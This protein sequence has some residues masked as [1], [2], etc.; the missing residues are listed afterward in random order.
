V[1]AARACAFAGAGTPRKES[2]KLIVDVHTHIGELE[3]YGELFREGEERGAT[4]ARSTGLA[5]TLAAHWEAMRDI[6]RAIVVGFKTRLLGC[7]VPNDYVAAYVNQHPEKL[8]GFMSVDPTQAGAV[9]EFERCH[10]DLGLRGIKMSPI[11]QGFHP[12]AAEVLPLYE[13]AQRHGLP[14]L[15]HQAACYNRVAPL[16]Y[17]HPLLFDEIAI[18]FPELTLVFAHL[19]Y[20]WKEETLHVVRKHP[21]VFADISFACSRPWTF[22]NALAYYA[23]WNVLDKLL[24]GSDFPAAGTSAGVMRALRSVNDPIEGTRLPRI[25]DEEIESIIR[26]DSLQLLRLE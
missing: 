9:E 6:D 3:H 10:H 12:H 17:A 7:D 23:E 18:R 19:G 15:L 22:Y 8:I 5:T 4:L 14:I 16:E 26:R 21:H 2:G 24:F 25:P 1:D 20:P 13:K 11:Y